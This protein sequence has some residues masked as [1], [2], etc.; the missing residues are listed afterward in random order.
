MDV[1][2]KVHDGVDVRTFDILQADA[3]FKYDWVVSSGVFNAK[4]SF[5]DNL[6][7]IKKML[8]KMYDICNKGVAVDFMSTYVDFQHQDAYHT[9]PFDII[10]FAKKELKANV[11]LRMDYLPYEYCVYLKK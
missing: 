3:D 4:L 9:S 1:A 2:K 10:D 11:V 8:Y 6:T 7:Y 5:E